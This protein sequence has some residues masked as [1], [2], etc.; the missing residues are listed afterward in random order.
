MNDV[1]LFPGLPTKI[2]YHPI[3]WISF[4]GSRLANTFQSLANSF[5]GRSERAIILDRHGARTVYLRPSKNT[6]LR[7]DETYSSGNVF[8]K[9]D[10]GE[11]MAN[12]VH[13]NWGEV[14]DTEESDFVAST[15]YQDR[16]E[17]N[18][19][20]DLLDVEL[21]DDLDNRI[22]FGFLGNAMLTAIVLI[23]VVQSAV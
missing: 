11:I 3:T 13:P 14:K 22:L 12:Q 2:Y 4:M 23:M 16:M 8:V 17:N 15:R 6:G 7:F 18:Y 5:S 20:E 19:W 10:G 9:S 21:D 1:G